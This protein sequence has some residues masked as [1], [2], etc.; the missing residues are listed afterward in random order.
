MNV[1]ARMDCAKNII[2]EWFLYVIY[3]DWTTS[4]LHKKNRGFDIPYVIKK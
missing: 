3:I 2:F 4:P 1:K